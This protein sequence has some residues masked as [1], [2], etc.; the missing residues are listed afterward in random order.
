MKTR[1]ICVITGSRAE[2]GHMLMLMKAIEADR[3]LRLQVVV[4]GMHL[5]SAFGHTFRVIE[6]DGFSIDARLPILK[7]DNTPEGICRSIGL[8]TALIARSLGKLKPDIVVICGDRYEMLAA[9]TAAH[10]LGIPIAHLHGGENSE[11]AIDEA[12]R[13]AITKMS[14]LHFAATEP[15]RRRIIQMGEQPSRVFNFGAPGQDLILNT[16][17]MGREDLA[18]ALGFDLTGPVALVTFHPVTLEKNS[19]E[20]QVKAV[21][22]ALVSSGLRGIIT[23]SNADQGGARI[24]ALMETFCLRHPRRFRLFSNL[25]AKIYFNCL[26]Y[27]DLLVGNSSSGIVEAPTFRLPVVNIGD[28]QQARVR[29]SNVIDVACESAAIKKGISQALSPAFK[30]SL[31]GMRN[32]YGSGSDGKVSE[33]IKDVLKSAEIGGKLLK[34]KFYNIKF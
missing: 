16:P 4:T 19:V 10:V 20:E 2:Y 30:R 34:K 31:K 32:P 11:G 26:R 28:R 21:T 3:G 24:N 8:G 6:K 13:H 17:V 15:Y 25:G 9:A 14:S 22:V 7:F 5:S 12:F 23:R 1:R 18:R 27:A 29:S 33:R